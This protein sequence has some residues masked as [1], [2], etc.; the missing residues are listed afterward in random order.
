MVG[1]KGSIRTVTDT[2]EAYVHTC[3]NVQESV[4]KQV[5]DASKQD[6]PGSAETSAHQCNASNALKQRG[7]VPYIFDMETGDPDDVLTLLFLAA[8]PCVELRAVTIT[9]GTTEQVA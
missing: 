5:I 3:M 8:H 4:S 9:P 1:S 2:L 6:A 7:S